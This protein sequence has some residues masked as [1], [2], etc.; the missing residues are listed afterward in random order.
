MGLGS[1][2]YISY[3]A[4]VAHHLHRINLDHNS[5]HKMRSELNKVCGS[6]GS[7][8]SE[9]EGRIQK[10]QTKGA[11][12]LGSALLPVGVEYWYP[13]PYHS[14]Y[15]SSTATAKTSS[16]TTSSLSF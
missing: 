10:Q 1:T 11:S 6:C 9:D 8:K 7:G 3:S 14:T 13:H 5:A 15:M 12:K 2:D 4:L 16:S